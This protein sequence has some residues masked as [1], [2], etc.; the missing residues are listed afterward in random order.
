MTTT[1]SRKPRAD[2][3]R[4][5]QRLLEIAKTKFAVKGESATLDEIAKTA[6]V[7]IGTLYRHFPTREALLEEVYRNES[8]QLS[9]AAHSLQDGLPAWEALRQWLLLFAD[10]LA[11]KQ[12]MTEALNE[13]GPSSG[14]QLTDTAMALVANAEKESGR[15]LGLSAVELLAA[16]AGVVKVAKGPDYGA[17]ARAL[18]DALLQ[19]LQARRA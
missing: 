13:Q 10:Y 16:I 12:L 19:G 17:G 2:A 4:N 3:E 7:G 11:N 15:Q 18:V 14:Q 9:A 5:K 8:E 1:I 6:G